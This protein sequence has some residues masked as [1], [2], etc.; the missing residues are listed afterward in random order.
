MQATGPKISS[1]AMRMLLCQIG[2]HGWPLEE[3]AL[4]G[5]GTAGDQ[6]GS[7]LLSDLKVV[8]HL[9]QLMRRGDRADLGFGSVEVTDPQPVPLLGVP[10][11]ELVVHIVLN[12]DPGPGVAPELANTRNS[13]AWARAVTVKYAPARR[14]A[15]HTAAL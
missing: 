13:V 9:V 11:H 7:L 3:P 5:P 4:Q 10:G 15:W 6:L 12:E 14:T 2:E 1:R 8:F